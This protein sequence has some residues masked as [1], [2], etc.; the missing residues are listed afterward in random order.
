MINDEILNSIKDIIKSDEAYLVG[1]YLRNYFLN[2]SVSFDRDIVC[3]NS[4]KEIAY[5][6][7][8]KLDGT[9]I[10]LDNLNE[11]YRVV[12]KD[13]K[14]Y[15]DVAKMSEKNLIEDIKRRD[16]T[17]NSIFYDL[18]NDKIID[19]YNGINDIK[20][21]ILRTADL[22]NYISDPLRF[23]RVYRFMSQLG[24][25]IENNLNDFIVKNFSLIKKTAPERINHEI[26]EIFKGEFLVD[27]L[28]KMLDDNTLEIVFPFV[29]EIK[30]VPKNS[31]H[32]LDLIHHSIETVKNIRT[33]N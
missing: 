33:N 20:N 1:G 15:F 21:K 4:S 26:I 32:H 29:K 14:N 11:I 25:K 18:N 22:N 9:F 6:I 23:L 24:F 13:K 2:N 10:E 19:P 31:H 8:K 17:I 7:S 5:K 30:Q 16:L 3:L 28:L 27:T 12:L